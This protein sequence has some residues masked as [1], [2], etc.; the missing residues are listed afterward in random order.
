M[1]RVYLIAAVASAWWMPHSEV[2]AQKE[3]PDTVPRIIEKWEP[4]YSLGIGKRAFCS[5]TIEELQPRS[6]DA[7]PGSGELRLR[8]NHVY[9]GPGELKGRFFAVYSVHASDLVTGVEGLASLEWRPFEKRLVIYGPGS[10]GGAWCW[11]PDPPMP[12]WRHLD[13]ENYDEVL[14]FFEAVERALEQADVNEHLRMLVREENYRPHAVWAAK[15]LA[16]SSPQEAASLFQDIVAAEEVSPHFACH[17]NCML[18]KLDSNWRLSSGRYALFERIT[19]AIERDLPTSKSTVLRHHYAVKLHNELVSTKLGFLDHVDSWEGHRFV[20]DGTLN[21]NLGTATRRALFDLACLRVGKGENDIP[22]CEGLKLILAVAGDT[23]T[24][25]ELYVAAADKLISPI[26]TDGKLTARTRWE[27]DYEKCSSVSELF[28]VARANVAHCE[29]GDPK[30]LASVHIYS[31]GL[32]ALLKNESHLT[33]DWQ[34]FYAKALG[35]PQAH[36]AL[37]AAVDFEQVEWASRSVSGVSHTKFADFRLANKYQMNEAVQNYFAAKD[38]AFRDKRPFWLHAFFI[39]VL[40]SP[41]VIFLRY[42]FKLLRV[43]R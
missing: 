29:P 37:A 10:F 12:V 9:R 6:T 36:V 16:T 21:T 30:Y 3:Q 14:L 20:R 41:F 8:I 39:A 2:S 19:S 1:L 4:E 13:A 42:E 33:D 31:Y 35:H 7:Y 24:P 25:P 28:Q 23:A 40:V 17:L 43:K 26:S 11:G 15:V 5:V 27:S 34:E 22:P 18:L 32:R 38:D